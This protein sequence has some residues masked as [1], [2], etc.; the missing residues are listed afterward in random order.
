M[1]ISKIICNRW[2]ISQFFVFSLKTKYDLNRHKQKHLGIK[3]HACDKCDYRGRDRNVLRRHIMSRHVAASMYP[4]QDCDERFSNMRL[5]KVCNCKLSKS[6]D[7]TNSVQFYECFAL[8]SVINSFILIMCRLQPNF[9]LNAQNV[10]FR[11]V[12]K[13][14]WL[15]VLH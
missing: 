12:Q 9:H 2:L 14:Y 4:C 8:F 3:N 1:Y 7:L 6:Q 15:W 13:A 5:L 10:A 11:L